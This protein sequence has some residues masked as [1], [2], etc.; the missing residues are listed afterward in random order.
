MISN[1][2][3]EN[4]IGNDIVGFIKSRG[5]LWVDHVERMTDEWMLKTDENV[6]FLIKYIFFCC[7]KSSY[8]FVKNSSESFHFTVKIVTN[9]DTFS[10][11]MSIV[12]TFN[13]PI[14]CAII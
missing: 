13:V 9:S 14:P 3:T 12:K 5:I 4:F 6:H 1:L 11:H 8:L 7:E 2:G 10:C